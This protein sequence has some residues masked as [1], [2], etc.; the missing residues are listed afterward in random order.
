M[1]IGFCNDFF[2]IIIL[3]E[4]NKQKFR[5]FISFFVTKNLKLKSLMSGKN[6]VNL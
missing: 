1:L 2:E 4:T 3:G 6:F 5:Q